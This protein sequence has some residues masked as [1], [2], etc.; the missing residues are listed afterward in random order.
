MF[1]YIKKI[2]VYHYSLFI[3]LSLECRSFMIKKYALGLYGHTL[4]YRG[5]RPR[6]IMLWVHKESPL[7]SAHLV[8][9]GQQQVTRS[10]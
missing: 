7:L 3:Y 10:H 4:F 5:G 9:G 8:L 6:M 1:V 2:F